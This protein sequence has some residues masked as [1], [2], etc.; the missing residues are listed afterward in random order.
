M[1]SLSV[2]FVSH[3]PGAGTLTALKKTIA[4]WRRRNRER[5]E[6]LSLDGRAIRDLG[7]TPQAVQF[8]ANKPFWRA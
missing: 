1:A 6:L 7:T 2:H 8:E 4:T 5:R 3:T